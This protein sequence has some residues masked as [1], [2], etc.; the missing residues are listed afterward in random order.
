MLTKLSSLFRRLL[1]SQL[2]LDRIVDHQIHKF[3]EAL[4]GSKLT[5]TILEA[6]CKNGL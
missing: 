1:C 2:D 6:D 5:R 3:V 4:F